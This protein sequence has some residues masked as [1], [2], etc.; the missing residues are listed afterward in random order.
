MKENELIEKIKSKDEK[1]LRFFI[2]NYGPILKGVIGKTLSFHKALI[3]EVLNDTTLAIWE[4]I[5]YFDPNRSSFKNW[6]AAIAKYKAIDALRREINHQ[7]LNID[8]VKNIKSEDKIDLGE[9]QEILKYL[10]EED[11]LIF[12]KIFLDGFSYDDLSKKTGKKKSF[13]YNR[14]SRAKKVLRKKLQGE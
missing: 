13:F 1:A 6:C 8:D 12:E 10:D 5:K 9:A 7:S 2:E 4:N 3:G 11:R 14:I